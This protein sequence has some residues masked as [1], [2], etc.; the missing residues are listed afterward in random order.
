MKISERDHQT[1]ESEIHDLLGQ[2]DTK[3]QLLSELRVQ[4]REFEHVSDRDF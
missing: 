3:D 2:I 4:I 1:M